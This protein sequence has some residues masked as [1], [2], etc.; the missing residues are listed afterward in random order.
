[1][2]EHRPR[3]LPVDPIGCRLH[4]PLTRQAFAS[5]ISSIP[6]KN[7]LDE[8]STHSDQRR[9]SVVGENRTEANRGSSLR[10]RQVKF[11]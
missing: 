2:D 4:S 1:M 5:N 8:E 3:L 6:Y 9:E 10:S 11:R 7:G